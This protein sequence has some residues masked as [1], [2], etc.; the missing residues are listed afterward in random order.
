MNSHSVV[1]PWPNRALHPN[2]R[3]HRMAL[4]RARKAARHDGWVATIAS[5]E[6]NERRRLAK[7]DGIEVRVTFNPPDRRVRDDDGCIA[8]V[9][10]HRDGVADAIGVDD[11]RW[12]V[13]YA[14]GEPVDG[15]RVTVEVF[16]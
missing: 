3:V 4:A 2:A 16:G 15:G 5:I 12:R 10:S 7:A 8:A 9:K 13:S 11:G 14:F 1:L 6:P